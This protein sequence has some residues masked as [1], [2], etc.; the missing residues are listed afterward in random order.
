MAA[1]SAYRTRILNS[2]KG[3]N[4][5]FENDVVDE[6]LRKALSEYSAVFPN[7]KTYE[8]TVTAAGRNQ[9]ISAVVDLTN[10]I[11]VVHPY[12]AGLA[13]PFVHQ[14]E[15]FT[16]SFIAGLPNLYFSATDIPQIGEKIY[17][18]YGASQ[19]IK[20]LDSETATTVRADHESALVCG[21]AAI[22]AMARSAGIIEMYGGKPGDPNQ[23]LMW[24]R[25]LYGQFQQFLVTIRSDQSLDLF[26]N[27]Y[28][29][30]DGW[31]G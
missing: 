16:L 3:T 22:A 11:Q 9:T 30:L 26:P 24:G 25:Q 17:L 4:T 28:W 18:L 23:L 7:M 14:R 19:T 10:L 15:D 13:N 12:D 27:A 8:Y 29:R 20:D 5:Q 2:L 6:A 21:A 1:L 31:D